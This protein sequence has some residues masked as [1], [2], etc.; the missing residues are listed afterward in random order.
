M[1][2]AT[3]YYSLSTPKALVVLIPGNEIAEFFV[4]HRFN[5]HQMHVPLRSIKEMD[6]SCTGSSM[7]SVDVTMC[8]IPTISSGSY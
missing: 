2:A 6:Q 4:A 3:H 5:T 1:L 7:K 8:L